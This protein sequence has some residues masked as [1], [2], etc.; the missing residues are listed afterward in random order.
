[1][2]G[3]TTTATQ[4]EVTL[5]IQMDRGADL[6]GMDLEGTIHPQMTLTMERSATLK[7]TSQP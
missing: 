4:V 2:A 3:L 5:I 1:M 7:V 6:I